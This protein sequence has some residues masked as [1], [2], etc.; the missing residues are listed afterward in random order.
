MP[1]VLTHDFFG[2][3][4]YDG[5]ASL[6][7]FSGDDQR[8]AF[9][10]GNQGPDPL[11]YLRVEPWV[12][13]RN[14]VGGLM[15]DARPAHLLCAFHDA[16]DMLGEQ[17]RPIGEAYVAGF[18][19][20]YLLDSTMHPLVFF[21]EHGI[22]DAGI[23]GLDRSD[24]GD[25]HAEIERDYDE[26]VLFSKTGKTI[27]DYR[28][29]REVLRGSAEVLAAIDKLYFY[30]CLW[31]YSTTIDLDTFTKAVYGFRVMQRVFWSPKGAGHK[32]LGTVERTFG[33]KQY[34]FYCAMAHRNR[35]EAFSDFDN[36]A[37]LPWENPF[38]GVTST[39]SFWDLYEEAQS[40]VF[41]AERALL[42]RDFD[43]A[44]AERL[45]GGLNFSGKPVSEDDPFE[46]PGR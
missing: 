42:S 21:Y 18:C 23:A 46:L 6:L 25:V 13:K 41:D 36:R 1:A 31:T 39:E 24:G 35:A 27:S 22:C 2:R 14:S 26:M 11:F 28:T 38:T 30:A 32:V 3:D 19:C 15:H 8:D 43:L 7:G 12:D 9:L 20:H 10:L 40:K 5:V 37:H 45:T 17:D 34:S 16:L 33:G 29:Y 4:A 44:A